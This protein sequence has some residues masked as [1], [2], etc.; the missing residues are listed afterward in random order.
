MRKKSKLVYGFGVS[1]ADYPTQLHAVVNGKRKRLW[2]CPVYRTWMHMLE[3]CYSV[4]FQVK[5]PAYT[6]CS[7]ASEWHIFSVFREWMLTQE[8]SDKHLDKDILY[9]GNKLYSP[10][11]CVFIPAALNKFLVGSASNRGDCPVGFY[12]N[13]QAGKY[14]A[15][16]KN[17]FTKN[18][19][20]LG[21]FTN[22]LEAH[23]AWRS[24]KH[25]HA[26][27]YADQQADPRIAKALRHRYSGIN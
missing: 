23:E 27:R 18:N 3:R 25:E 24:R 13:K 11:R 4:D 5:N 17:P 14:A 9:L 22:P 16:C 12:W 1:D 15:Q 10:E 7:V 8:W 21:Y 19:Q 26:C 2:M 20:F 6:G